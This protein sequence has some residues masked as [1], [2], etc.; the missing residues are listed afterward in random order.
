VTVAGLTLLYAACLMS[1]YIVIVIMYS[2][3]QNPL[4]TSLI[5]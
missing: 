2:V 5:L 3:L 1:L 4:V